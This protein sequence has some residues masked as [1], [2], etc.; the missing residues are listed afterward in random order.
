MNL[1]E[2]FDEYFNKIGESLDSSL[3]INWS[4]IK[5]GYL[6]QFNVDDWNYKI[7]YLK[8]I[9]NNWSFSFSYFDKDKNIWSYQISHKGT[10]GLNVLSTIKEGLY[11][12]YN[13]TKPNSIIFSAIDS[14]DTRKRLYQSFCEEFC[15]KNN[16]KFSNRGNNDSQIFVMFDDSVSNEHKEEI[17]QSVKKIVETGK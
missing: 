12:M 7:E 11:N 3:D 9:G 6:G 14:S 4:V 8:Q 16:W 13:F 15:Q 5:N 1:I 17:M 2:K 10:S